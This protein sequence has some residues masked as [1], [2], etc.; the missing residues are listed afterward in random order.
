[1]PN[2]VFNKVSFCGPSKDVRLLLKNIKSIKRTVPQKVV[3]STVIDFEKIRP[4]PPALRNITSPVRIVT[5]EQY[6]E[7]ID[8][9][10]N[11]RKN[12]P[13]DWFN[14]TH[15]ITQ[16]MCDRYVDEYGHADWYSWAI[17]NWGT[18]WNACDSRMG[19]SRLDKDTDTLTQVITFNTAWATPEPV[20]LALSEQYPTVQLNVT[21]ADEDA[22]F[23]CGSYCLFKG[24]EIDLYLPEGGT[25]DAMEIYFSLWGGEDEW[26]VDENGRYN[27]K[28]E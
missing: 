8:Q 23:N 9:W 4:M 19:E 25:K 1:M 26:V 27:F 22:G 3:E 2:Y 10:S 13:D 11:H 21:F 24:A 12:H 17:D 20:L 18:K 15:S 16:E 5:Q 7:E 28:E 6:D 14:M